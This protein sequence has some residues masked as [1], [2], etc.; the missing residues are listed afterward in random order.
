MKKQPR[1]NKT[2]DELLADLKG[3]EK[4][5]EKM[6]FTRDKFYPALCNASVSIDDASILLSG[7]NTMIMQEFLG[8]MKDVKLSELNLQN[9]LEP[10]NLK[11]DE[12]KAL[13]DLFAEMNVFDAKDYIE[14]MR[15]EINL[16]LTEEAKERPLKDL[17]V[18][19]LD[20]L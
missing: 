18:K 16:F 14:G 10:T 13:L 15:N 17:K 9:K 11:F 3:N 7:M 5:Q 12:S 2:K 1:I 6:A 4:F 20:Q 19:W 8:K